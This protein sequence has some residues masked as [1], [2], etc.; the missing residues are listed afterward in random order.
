MNKTKPGTPEVTVSNVPD[1]QNQC[2]F[3]R[4]DRINYLNINAL[5]TKVLNLKN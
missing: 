4:K 1:N 5:C 2:G 3:D